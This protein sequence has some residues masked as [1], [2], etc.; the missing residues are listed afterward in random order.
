MTL[1]WVASTEGMTF[2]T[3]EEQD[4]HTPPGGKSPGCAGKKERRPEG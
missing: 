2:V 4:R 1:L 3:E